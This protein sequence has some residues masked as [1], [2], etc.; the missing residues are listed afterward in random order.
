[1][2]RETLK[3]AI[4]LDEPIDELPPVAIS[5]TEIE[6]PKVDDSIKENAMSSIIA[7]EIS[8]TYNSIDSI[9]SIIAT[10]SSEM[11]EREDIVAIL[12]QIIDDKTIHVGMLQKAIDL[13]DGKTNELIDNGIE[14]AEVAS[15]VGEEGE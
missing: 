2:K 10:I 7:N 6:E 13:I 9:K 11:P 12:N 5:T 8:S 1:M 15:L 4:L 14:A 3:E